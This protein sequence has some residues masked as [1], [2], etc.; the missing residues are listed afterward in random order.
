MH[1][2]KT[3]KKQL[4]DKSIVDMFNQMIGASNADPV[5][6]LPKY[7]KLK[8]KI[9]ALS[10]ILGVLVKDILVRYYPEQSPE[11]TGIVAY[12]NTLNTLV[13]L[14]VDEKSTPDEKLNDEYKL[15]KDNNIVKNIII[16]Y[17]SLIPHT[18]NL[19][20]GDDTF[21][22]RIPG[23]EYTP[24]PFSCLNLKILW[25]H[26]NINA[27]SKRAI[28]TVLKIMLETVKCIY[29]VII[30]PDVD[31][32]DFSNAIVASIAQV[33]KH[34]PRCDRAF[35]K[36]EESVGILEGNF[37]SYYKDFVQSKNP[38]TMIESFVIDVAKEGE[39]DA[40]T[41]RQ[42]RTIINYYRKSTQGKIKDPKVKKIF[43]ML[44]ANFNM[45]SEE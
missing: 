40:Q 3:I 28:M 35:A 20:T 13:F 14:E 23:L 19:E 37:S 29:E 42:F 43:D 15:L 5:I 8:K 2:T 34:I 30:S 41:T 7:I 10:Q 11:C 6:I 24:F 38:S 26:D 31:V 1:K 27:H 18:N 25:V 45:M 39:T 12:A 17:K 9:Q 33:K 32:K 44:N 16:L 22:S 21:V 4:T 36:I